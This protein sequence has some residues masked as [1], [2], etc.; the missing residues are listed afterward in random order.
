MASPW[1]GGRSGGGRT[2]QAPR[3]FLCTESSQEG[4]FQSPLLPALT[5][6]FPLLPPSSRSP[7]VWQEPG[8]HRSENEDISQMACPRGCALAG[9]T[10]AG[11]AGPDPWLSPKHPNYVPSLAA[12]P[13]QC[14]PPP[15][16]PSDPGS[17]RR[18]A[19][20]K[21]PAAPPLPRA[22]LG[23][24]G[25]PRVG[26]GRGWHVLPGLPTALAWPRRPERHCSGEC[27]RGGE[28]QLARPVLLA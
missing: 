22:E 27:P 20:R 15:P 25:G 5:F 14:L 9:R 28:G 18:S 11:G 10:G 8:Q 16:P 7:R 3:C 1:D 24:L 19:G 23:R 26:A 12:K 2:W 4:V 21:G 17:A 6:T 13:Q